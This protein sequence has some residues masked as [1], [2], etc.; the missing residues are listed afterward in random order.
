MAGWSPQRNRPDRRPR[1]STAG[2]GHSG[3]A[4]DRVVAGSWLDVTMLLWVMVGLGL[5]RKLGDGVI[6]TVRK[7]GYRLRGDPLAAPGDK[8]QPAS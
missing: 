1:S 8:G 4:R 3:P 5:R 6:E 7:A 2:S